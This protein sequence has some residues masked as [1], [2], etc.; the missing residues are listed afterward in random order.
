MSVNNTGVSKFGG[1]LPEWVVL[2]DNVIVKPF[3]C[4]GMAGFGFQVGKKGKYRIPLVR[5]PH[6]FKVVIGHDVEIGCGCCIDRGSWRDSII[7][8]GT[9]L[10]NLIHTG[11]NT[12]IGKH[13]LIAV[14]ATIGGSVTIGDF[15][16]IGMNAMIGQGLTIT[17]KVTIGMGSVVLKDIVEEN[18]TWAGNPARK[19]R[20]EQVN[21]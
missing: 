20:D 19:I 11:H 2:G 17:N 12:Q 3:T 15:C 21:L 5:K 1:G 10:D 9:K 8:S 4:I 13:C 18:T 6:N 14:G 16:E 7:G